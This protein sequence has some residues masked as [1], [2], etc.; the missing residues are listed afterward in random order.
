MT[1]GKTIAL[2]RMTFVDKVISLLFNRLSRLIIAFLQRN[3]HLLITWLQLPSTV[4]L[5]T[6]KESVTVPIVPPSICHDESESRAWKS[7]LKA[8]HSENEDHGIWS[9]HFMGNRWGNSGDRVRLYFWG[10][11][12]HF[13]REAWC[14]VIHG[15]K[16]IHTWLSN[17]TELNWW[18]L[19]P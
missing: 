13:H 14:A 3:K 9:H 5:E 4:I 11:Q 12:K 2:T 10:F 1:T 8:Q 18:D 17:W 6:K 16:K 7:G 19:M 15:V